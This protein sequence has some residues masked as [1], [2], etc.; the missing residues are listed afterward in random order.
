MTTNPVMFPQTVFPSLHTQKLPWVCVYVGGGGWALGSQEGRV[1]DVEL[2]GQ[3][4]CFAA[5][6]ERSIKEKPNTSRALVDVLRHTL[7]NSYHIK[8]DNQSYECI[9]YFLVE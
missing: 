3:D 7:E 2:T 5:Y 1:V 6:E 8:T 9:L 4:A